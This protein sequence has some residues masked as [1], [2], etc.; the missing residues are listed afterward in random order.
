[1]K[2]V[3]DG[4]HQIR[5]SDVDGSGSLLAETPGSRLE[6]RVALSVLA[7]LLLIG[8]YFLLQSHAIHVSRADCNRMYRK[9][10]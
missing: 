5:L 6:K 3:D 1:M 8:G 7:I 10:N 4:D 2:K 9:G